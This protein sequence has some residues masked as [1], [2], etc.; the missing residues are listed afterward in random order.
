MA[1]NI[2]P[3]AE[4]ARSPLNFLMSSMRPSM[5]SVDTSAFG[6]GCRLTS[7]LPVA[8]FIL[9][10]SFCFLWL[11]VRVFDDPEHIAPGIEHIG[12]ENAFAHVLDL[13]TRRGSE[14]EQPGV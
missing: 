14:F 7:K 12:D 11:V 1:D 2:W 6:S 3:R 8:L 4:A 5:T 10:T 13:A 9:K